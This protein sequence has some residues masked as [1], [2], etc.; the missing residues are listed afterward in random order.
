[1]RDVHERAIINFVENVLLRFC[2]IS[3]ETVTLVV[4]F[5]VEVEE[6]LDK[7]LVTLRIFNS[8]RDAF[9]EFKG[10][11]ASYF[12]RLPPEQ[13]QVNSATKIVYISE[14]TPLFLYQEK[15]PKLWEFQEHLIFKRFDSFVD[16][17]N[18]V[19]EFFR[20]AQ[21]F[22]KLEKVE[23]GGIRGRALS[24]RIGSVHEEFKVGYISTLHNTFKVVVCAKK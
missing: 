13:Q 3:N 14:V 12:N 17:L 6:A 8:F 4:A 2:S 24:S 23:I 22:L 1:M 7:V 20:T 16:R 19:K 10:K 18:I 21:Q 5:Q 9:R 15:K 11:L